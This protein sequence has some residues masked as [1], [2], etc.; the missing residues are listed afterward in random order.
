MTRRHKCKIFRTKKLCS[1]NKKKN[2]STSRNLNKPNKRSES[3]TE[4]Q[5][6]LKRSTRNWRNRREESASSW[7][8]IKRR[9]RRPSP[10]K[11]PRRRRSKSL[12]KMKKTKIISRMHPSITSLELSRKLLLSLIKKTPMTLLSRSYS[13]RT[14]PSQTNV[15]FT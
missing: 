12:R 10:R 2:Y 5:S 11:S 6:K 4:N 15:N 8:K 1:K 9:Y 3:S 13:T 14:W 7:S